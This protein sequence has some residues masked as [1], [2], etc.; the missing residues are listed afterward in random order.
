MKQFILALAIMFIGTFAYSQDTAS[1]PVLEPVTDTV[2]VPSED[3]TL[4]KIDEVVD[5][6]G[7]LTG[8]DTLANI[9]EAYAAV[10]AKIEEAKALKGS[11][12]YA[13]LSYAV[14][15]VALLFGVWK[16]VLDK[17]K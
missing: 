7:L 17:K 14:S 4:V 2:S 11:P 13:W 8:V 1:V 9:D 10:T 3:G 16:L 5:K 15:L 12:W 6:L